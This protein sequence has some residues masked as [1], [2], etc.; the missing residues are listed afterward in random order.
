M[1]FLSTTDRPVIDSRVVLAGAGQDNGK[2][3]CG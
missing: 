1:Q 2:R 3:K